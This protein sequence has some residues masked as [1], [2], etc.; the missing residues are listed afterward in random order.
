MDTSQYHIPVVS[1]LNATV[2]FVATAAAWLNV[3][4]ILVILLQ[5]VLRYGFHN[6]LVAL[7]ELMWHLF[8]IA[9]MFGLA[10]G[11]VNN[12][13]IRVDVVYSM[14]SLS[15]QRVIE[16][17]GIL[18]LLFPVL[19]ILFDHSLPWAYESFLRGESSN[20]PTGLPYRWIVKA[21]IPLTC[22]LMFMASFARLVEQVQMLRGDKG[23]STHSSFWL[24]RLFAWSLIEKRGQHG[25]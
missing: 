20:N 9:F 23:I 3:L 7:E 2:R 12:S 5:V 17:L 14:L 16:I 19:W 4:L 10:Q 11:I 6:G 22:V 15:K 25:A 18:F 13:H 1:H 21:V 24:S 8:A